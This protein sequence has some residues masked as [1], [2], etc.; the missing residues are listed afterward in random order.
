MTVPARPVGA[1]LPFPLGRPTRS[2]GRRPRAAT[3]CVIAPLLYIWGDDELLA[4]AARGRFAA[5]A[6]G[7]ARRAARAL[8]PA[9]DPTTATADAAQLYERLA[10]PPMFGGGT[11]AVVANP[12][13]LTVA[14]TRATA[15][16]RR[17]GSWRPGNALVFL[18][19]A[20]SNAKGPGPKRL[21]DA[22][23]AAGG[24][25]S[26]R[27]GARVRRRSRAWISD[28]AR[29]RG[30]P[31]APWRRAGAGRPARGARDG[32]RRRPAVPEPDR[33]G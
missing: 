14:T 22:V 31:L 10:T 19:A 18:E 24:R 7:R 5:R 6:R 29:E 9:A 21:A 8:G 13:A 3:P 26:R 1:A 23:K 28:E 27:D 30:L 15:S 2:T 20:K 4:A 17:S 33:L 16:S 12:G 11:L 25:S 32:G